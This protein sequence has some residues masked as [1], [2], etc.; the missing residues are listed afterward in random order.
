MHFIK[1]WNRKG[2]LWVSIRLGTIS[3][4]TRAHSC[5][6]TGQQWCSIHAHAL[7]GGHLSRQHLHEAVV[8]LSGGGKWRKRVERWVELKGYMCSSGFNETRA[9]FRLAH[10][11]KRCLGCEMDRMSTGGRHTFLSLWHILEN[12]IHR[13]VYDFNLSLEVLFYR[14]DHKWGTGPN[15]IIEAFLHVHKPQAI[16]AEEVKCATELLRC[17]YQETQP[18]CERRSLSVFKGKRGT[19]GRKWGNRKRMKE[20]K[21]GALKGSACPCSAE[22]TKHIIHLLFP[23]RHLRQLLNTR[24]WELSPHSS[25]SVP[26]PFI[27]PFLIFQFPPPHPLWSALHPH[28]PTPYPSSSHPHLIPS[29]QRLVINVSFNCHAHFYA[30]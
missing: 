30:H 1:K 22:G 24:I 9:S 27:H 4:A 10:R 23:W 5:M 11:G 25:S 18:L 12:W 2:I 26:P 20:N 21:K 7:P 13:G 14:T 19:K 29:L 3:M 28:P 16:K 6:Q 17:R 8:W 15:Q